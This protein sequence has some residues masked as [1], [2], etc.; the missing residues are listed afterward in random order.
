M[1]WLTADET[2]TRYRITVKGLLKQRTEGRLPGSLGKRVGKRVLWASEDLDRHD[3]PEE[4]PV[5]YTHESDSFGAL[6]AL[7]LEAPRDEHTFGLADRLRSWSWSTDPDAL[8]R[9]YRPRSQRMSERRSSTTRRHDRPSRSTTRLTGCAGRSSASGNTS[10][11]SS[12]PCTTTTG[13]R[14]SA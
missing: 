2:A 4:T 10:H 11:G 7:I 13:K 14:S 12:K 1:P 3:H 6:H 5:A 8:P 9:N